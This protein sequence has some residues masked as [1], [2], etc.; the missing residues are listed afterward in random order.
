M[1]PAPKA[2]LTPAP[3]PMLAPAPSPVFPPVLTSMD[4]FPFTL[5]IVRRIG[6]SR[7]AHVSAWKLAER[8]GHVQTVGGRRNWRAD[9]SSPLSSD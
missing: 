3:R 8:G 7:P 1:L 5:R 9:A 4:L 2:M 6:P